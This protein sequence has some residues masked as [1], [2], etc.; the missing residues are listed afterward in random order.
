MMTIVGVSL[1]FI[2]LIIALSPSEKRKRGNT[3]SDFLMRRDNIDRERPFV[4]DAL[5]MLK[6]EEDDCRKT[7][8]R[9]LT[10]YY[11]TDKKETLLDTDLDESQMESYNQ[12][13][14]T[15]DLLKQ[16]DKI[17]LISSKDVNLTTKSS[18]TY[19]VNRQQASFT[20]SQFNHVRIADAEYIPEIRDTNF[21]YYIYPRFIIKAKNGIDFE[22][23]PIDKVSCSC[24]PQRFVEDEYDFMLPKDGKVVD[25]TYR[26]VNK[27]GTPDRRY[28]DNKKVPVFL[29]GELAIEPFGLKYHVSNYEIAQKFEHVFRNFQGNKNVE[30][31]KPNPEVFDTILPDYYHLCKEMA[32]TIY[33]YIK[34]LEEDNGFMTF[35]K[36]I[37]GL[38]SLDEVGSFTINPRLCI[39]FLYDLI[40]CYKNLGHELTTFSKEQLCPAFVTGLLMGHDVVSQD[41]LQDYIKK[42]LPHILS[43]LSTIDD[44]KDNEMA[45]SYAFYLPRIFEAY[46]KE[47]INEYMVLLYRYSSLIAKADGT[48]SELETRWLEGLMRKKHIESEND[49][50]DIVPVPQQQTKMIPNKNN[51]AI[52]ELNSMIGLREVKN[53]IGK[54][55]NYI[56]IQKVRKEQGLKTSSLSYHC[57][58]TGNPG[59]GKT[60]VARIV[61]E[62]YRE[63]GILS[64]GHLVETDRSGLVAEYVGQTAVKTN[65]IIDTALDGVLFIDE[66]YSLA[67]GGGRDYGM[68]AISTLLKRMEDD[69]TRLVVILAGYG[70]EMQ[71]FINANPG[72][73]SRFNRYIHFE[74]Y[75]ANELFSIFELNAKK[76]DYII[77]PEAEKA[78]RCI[79][80]NAVINKDKN[81][82]NARFIRNLFEET[83]E[84][85]S[86]RLAQKGTLSKEILQL[87]TE[88]DIRK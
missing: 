78:L 58:F 57:I 6:T 4:S 21:S 85:Q 52:E 88:E 47:R 18:A 44:I 41:L 63:L 73:Q 20:S 43:T 65:K 36:G 48:I 61:A 24:L 39:L 23:V 10:D 81:F 74:D 11:K 9:G 55:T 29:Y 46:D 42:V 22:I 87:I 53:E 72:L 1:F 8:L 49:K 76:L 12:L 50:T 56:K 71:N 32:K 31:D 16:C 38:N 5:K 68:E 28:S 75:S 66:A 59:T 34:E 86:V 54:L 84:N 62:V 45:D 25:Y 70:N 26:Y 35:T 14:E 51:H 69:R 33:T 27:N 2:I 77:S 17:W 67:Q 60:T 64:K 19:F 30:T 3:P 13:L 79:I 40:K 15:F 83:I 37:G 82:G 80:E 7:F